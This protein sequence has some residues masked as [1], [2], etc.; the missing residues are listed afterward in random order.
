M[1]RRQEPLQTQRWRASLWVIVFVAASL[2]GCSDEGLSPSEGRPSEG[3]PRLQVAPAGV[4]VSEP[5]GGAA[6]DAA[7]AAGAQGMVYVSADP[8]TFLDA[9]SATVTNPATGESVTAEIVDGGFDPVAIPGSPGDELEISAHYGDGTSV[10]Y[11]STVPA[12]KRPRV[13]R[14][15]PSKD[16]VGVPLNANIVVVLSEPVD[17]STVTLET[18]RLLHDGVAVAATLTLDAEGL[19]AELVPDVSL[20]PQSAYTLDITTGIVD[21]GGDPLEKAVAVSFTTASATLLNQ[22]VFESRGCPYG[23]PCQS[24]PSGEIYVMNLDG[25]GVVNLTNS[26]YDDHNPAVSPDGTRILFASDRGP[27]NDE[28][29][30]MNADGSGLV[31]LT[32]NPA[33]DSDPVWSPDGTKIAF[34]SS[35]DGCCGDYLA[36]PSSRQD[37]FVMNADGSNPVNLT[38]NAA[39]YESEPAWSPDGRKIAFTS[40]RSSGQVRQIDVFVINAN[41]SNIVNLTASHEW[42]GSAPAWSPDGTKIAYTSARGDASACVDV[43]VMNVDGSNPVNVTY[44]YHPGGPY[45]CYN[46]KASWS[47]DGESLVFAAVFGQPIYVASY[48]VFR[49][50]PGGSPFNLTPNRRETNDFVGS[51]QAWSPRR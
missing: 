49:V 30:V 47:P 34:T 15:R 44:P 33:F 43:L 3:G 36:E 5:V 16:A 11:R 2:A 40:D 46:R 29:Y 9:L 24:D 19:Q 21:L 41:G 51:P 28:I 42:G 8:G 17:P 20:S 1:I 50:F 6:A 7:L 27:G 10:R 32:N 22:V 18:I 31:N 45:L 48:D 14:T 37:I 23:D 13:V 35:R 25:S 26:P 38:N 4:A 39:A 12:R